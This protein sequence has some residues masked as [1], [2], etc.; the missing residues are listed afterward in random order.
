MEAVALDNIK[1]LQIKNSAG[2]VV[3]AGYLLSTSNTDGTL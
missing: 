2:S 1:P 3:L